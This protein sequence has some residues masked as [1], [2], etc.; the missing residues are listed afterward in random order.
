MS[1][2]I[3][4]LLLEGKANLRDCGEVTVPSSEAMAQAPP[5]V[6]KRIESVEEVDLSGVWNL[7]GGSYQDVLIS[8][9]VIPGKN[10]CG[11]VLSVG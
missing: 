9:G 1:P 4:V 8:Q 6:I 2:L 7:T 10:F 3:F 11:T 5:D